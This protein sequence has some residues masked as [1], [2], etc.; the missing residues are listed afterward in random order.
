MIHRDVGILMN[1]TYSTR[2]AYLELAFALALFVLIAVIFGL[3]SLRISNSFVVEYERDTLSCRIRG[4]RKEMGN[5][6]LSLPI[7]QIRRCG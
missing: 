6:L 4:Y 2:C 5:H 3:P 7:R 1:P